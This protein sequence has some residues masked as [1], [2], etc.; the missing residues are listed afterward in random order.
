MV[1]NLPYGEDGEGGMKCREA[2]GQFAG[3]LDNNLS[4]EFRRRMKIHL[5]GCKKCQGELNRLKKEK[6]PPVA[7]QDTP[8]LQPDHVLLPVPLLSPEAEG[9][10]S[11]EV[12]PKVFSSFHYLPAVGAV[13]ILIILGG[14]AYFLSQGSTEPKPVP[15]AEATSSS[16]A[17]P[18]SSPADSTQASNS[19]AEAMPPPS[20]SNVPGE[21]EA[22]PMIKR[23][24]NGKPHDLLP[25]KSGNGKPH[26]LS[27][28]ARAKLVPKGPPVKLLLISRDL[29]EAVREVQSRAVQSEGKVLE[30]REGDLNAR[31]TLLLPASE[32]EPFFQ[33]LQQLGL[34]KVVSKQS[35]PAEGPVKL[36]LTIE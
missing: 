25:K 11:P 10:P 2:E 19:P 34:A 33:L 4:K 5:R 24:G 8:D 26:D 3:F 14:M 1:Y 27:M 18:P 9:L 35:P 28:G 29:K 36:E 32:Y 31:F 21:A 16:P 22:A 12:S 15:P 13:T 17:L 7:A 6:S 23:A 20:V 30:K